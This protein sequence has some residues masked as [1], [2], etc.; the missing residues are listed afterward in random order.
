MLLCSLNGKRYAGDLCL[1]IEYLRL[2][3]RFEYVLIIMTA[4]RWALL[5]VRYHTTALLK[6]LPF[7]QSVSLSSES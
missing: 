5:G 6:E 7:T 4:F 2:L 1:S 3:N